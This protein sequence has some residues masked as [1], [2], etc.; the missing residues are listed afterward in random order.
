M[1]EEAFT[2]ALRDDDWKYIEPVSKPVPDW[3]K[4]K[5]MATGLSSKPQLYNLKTDV[6][7]QHNLAGANPVQLKKMKVMMDIIKKSGTR[8]GF[9]K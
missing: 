9:K 1:L 8:P 6:Q 7:E 4:N 2:L 3:I 5:N